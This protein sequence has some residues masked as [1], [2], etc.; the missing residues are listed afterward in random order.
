MNI[1]EHLKILIFISYR[2]RVKKKLNQI[3][4]NIELCITSTVRK[5]NSKSKRVISGHVDRTLKRYQ[6]EF[7]S[8]LSILIL[9]PGYILEIYNEMVVKN[10]WEH[11]LEQEK[12][13]LFQPTTS[14]KN[15][16]NGDGG[17]MICAAGKSHKLCQFLELDGN[18]DVEVIRPQSMQSSALEMTANQHLKQIIDLCRHLFHDL[19]DETIQTR[20]LMFMNVTLEEDIAA[21]YKKDPSIENFQLGGRVSKSN[22]DDGG[23][24]IK[25]NDGDDRSL[26]TSLLS[27]IVNTKVVQDSVINSFREGKNCILLSH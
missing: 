9:E 23:G 12:L 1:D 27:A 22:N 18:I 11:C 25:S 7:T 10:K 13:G 20:Y 19:E 16:G 21:A 6:N 5:L 3:E 24:E 2:L 14:K 15:N 8:L 26:F 4:N 17:N